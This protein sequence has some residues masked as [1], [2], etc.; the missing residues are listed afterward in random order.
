[1]GAYV[2]PSN[3]SFRK[4]L[5][6]PLYVDKSEMICDLNNYF[7]TE[8]QYLCVSRARRFGKTMMANLISAYYSKGC[9]SRSLFEGLKL[10]QH[11]NWDRYLNSACVIKIDVNGWFRSTQDKNLTVQAIQSAVISELRTEFPSVQLP[12]EVGLA[13]ALVTINVALDETFVIIIDEYDVLFRENVSDSLRTEYLDLLNSLFKNDSLKP[14]ISLAYIT[15]ILPIIRDRV[16]SKLNNFLEFTML[17]P[18]E[19]APYFGFTEDE[20][21][22]LCDKTG[23]DFE[24]CQHMYD[25]YSFPKVSHVFNPNSVANAM[26]TGVYKSYW[27]ATSSYEA[28]TYY[29]DENID[30]IQTDI[31][32]LLGGG[33]VS[34]NTELY[35]NNVELF[36]SKDQLFTYLIHLGYLT[37][38][39][40]LTNSYC[41]IPNGEVHREWFNALEMAKGFKS[42]KD[43]LAP[44]RAVLE[45]TEH[46]DAPRVAAALDY[47][48]AQYSSSLT[49]NRE[50][51]LQSAILMAYFYARKDF[52]VFAEFPTGLGFADVALIPLRPGRAAIIIELKCD[53][54]GLSSTLTSPQSAI[55]QIK[56][57]NYAQALARHPGKDMG[58][59]LVGI[60]Y[61]A[62]TKKHQ[63]LIEHL[64]DCSEICH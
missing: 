27:T 18:F 46:L 37:I 62:K 10:A 58:V 26:R 5:R 45:A 4:A 20:V 33:E 6:M 7:D 30:G 44:T 19:L 47:F 50:S 41:C 25:G 48:H 34:V 51:S 24:Q 23:R 59:I 39:K 21:K 49:F 31:C 63:C 15:G 42:I 35:L 53:A 2:N 36:N 14:V 38:K 64:K 16:Q 22:E 54:E 12:E 55:E 56:S 43:L 3:I 11:P 8:N 17:E 13:N 40:E 60:T 9:D 57:R 32:T 52:M 28:I 61:N 29:I 1:M